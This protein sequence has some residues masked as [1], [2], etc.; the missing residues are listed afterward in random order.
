MPIL[1]KCAPLLYEQFRRDCQPQVDHLPVS[2]A[3]PLT[4]ASSMAGLD[5]HDGH[6]GGPACCPVP[7]MLGRLPLDRLI[8]QAYRDSTVD[9]PA[10]RIWMATRHG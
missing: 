7:T 9:E 5:A 6:R 2:P 1:L 4:P 8:C 10:V 3:L